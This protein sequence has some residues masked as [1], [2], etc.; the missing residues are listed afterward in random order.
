[1]SD[2]KVVKKPAKKRRRRSTKKDSAEQGTNM[3]SN[4]GNKEKEVP[5]SGS[6]QGSVSSQ[7]IY[8]GPRIPDF[9][10]TFPMQPSFP[11]PGTGW[12]PP[13]INMSDLSS[14][15]DFILS[16][17]QK[18]DTMATQQETIIARLNCIEASIAE[19]K[20]KIDTAN[21]KINEI[22]RSQNFINEKYESVS[23]EVDQ[24]KKQHDKLQGELK[25]LTKQNET[26]KKDN[27]TLMTDNKKCQED[28]IDLQ[29]RS[30]RDN[31]VF[32][33]IPE[34]VMQ[35]PP[36]GMQQNGVPMEQAN[37]HASSQGTFLPSQPQSTYAQV[38][39]GEDCTVKI[40]D[41]CEQV[42][43]IESAKTR[44][45]IDRAH[46]MGAFKHGKPRAIVVKFKDTNSKMLVKSA[47]KSINLKNTSFAVFEQYPQAVQERRKALIPEMVKARNSGKTAF[48]VK[49]KLLINGRPYV[50]PVAQ[51]QPQSGG[52]DAR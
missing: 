19:N 26:L 24:N 20:S 49:D 31:L 25:N 35:P 27:E 11:T 12:N 22:E 48:L 32:L 6:E 13:N 38:S 15:I 16:K 8:Q 21:R 5:K 51:Q 23:K 47:L 28:I 34:V 2:N 46:R 37:D 17:V 36:S 7:P 44:I 14:K 52:A 43:K 39:A 29:C 1:M 42:L 41:F 33:G 50:G 3:A 10:M 9:P 4:K 45:F 30:M 18:L 40:L